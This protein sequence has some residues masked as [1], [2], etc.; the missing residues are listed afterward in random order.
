MEPTEAAAESVGEVVEYKVVF[1]WSI[2]VAWDPS[3]GPVE[4]M[5]FPGVVR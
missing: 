2:I 3:G 5:V 1:I 4:A